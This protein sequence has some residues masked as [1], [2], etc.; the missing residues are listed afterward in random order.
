MPS[1]DDHNSETTE[2]GGDSPQEPLI[3]RQLE[4]DLLRQHLAVDGV[5]ESG[6][7]MPS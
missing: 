1:R 5:T 6:K 2:A 4:L 3:D 7:G